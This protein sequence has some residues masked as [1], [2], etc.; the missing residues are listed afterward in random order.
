MLLGVDLGGSGDELLGGL[1]VVLAGLGYADR[2]PARQAR[3]ADRPPIGVAAWVR[4]RE[5]V[6]LAPSR[7]SAARMPCP[8]LGPLAAVAVLGAV[9]TGFAFVILYELFATV[10]P[11]RAWTVTYM[12][13]GFAVAYG[14]MLLDERITLATVCGLALIVGGLVSGRRRGA[15]VAA[16][17]RRGAPRHGEGLAVTR[18]ESQEGK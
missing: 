8:A 18:P 12:A 16:T 14:A 10:G 4:R 2:R 3:C 6:V 15:T 9:G 1:A 5:R 11:W 7:R 13:P 17:A